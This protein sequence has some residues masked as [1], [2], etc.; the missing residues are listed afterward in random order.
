MTLTET[1]RNFKLFSKVFAVLATIVIVVRVTM[2]IYDVVIKIPELPEDI[3]VATTL[4]GPIPPLTVKT[5][6]MNLPTNFSIYL[7]LISG[8]LP[9]EPIVANV[10]PVLKAPYGFLSTDR[11]A[12]LAK[13]FGMLTKPVKLNTTESLW[14]AVNQT[15]KINDQSLNYFYQFNYIADP[16]VFIP[17][18]FL[19]QQSAIGSARAILNSH[20]L[21]EKDSLGV[22]EE[23]PDVFLLKYQNQLIQPTKRIIEASSIRIDFKRL[24]AIYELTP[25]KKESYPFVSPHY[26]GSL[27]YAMVS[28]TDTQG[29]TK[30]LE[31]SYTHWRYDATQGSTY[32]LVPSQTA[33]D[34]LQQDPT[35]FTVYL[36]NL[37]MGPLDKF[38]STPLIQTVIVKNVFLAYYNPDEAMDYIQPVWVFVGRGLIVNGGELDWVGYVPAVS[39]NFIQSATP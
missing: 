26:V 11:A 36:G 34:A 4:F 9:R 14:T 24:N 10:Y 25:G 33:W 21:N 17:G 18:R 31:A 29:G 27:V 7:D 13:T 1:S 20:K 35:V 8:D 37:E 39:P 38:T 3:P 2:L 15:L 5:V 23:T 12:D 16:S 32:P 22:D 19:N 30:T 28:S 6:S